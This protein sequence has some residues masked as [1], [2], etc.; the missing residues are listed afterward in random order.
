MEQQGLIKRVHGGAV[1]VSNM[2]QL[3]SL[4]IRNEEYSEEKKTLSMKAINSIE[5]GDIIFIDAGS[6][7]IYFSQ[8][9]KEKFS[10]LTVVT[11]SLDVF[12]ILCHQSDFDVILC[13]DHFKKEENAFYGYLAMSTLEKI[14]V[15]KVFVFPSAISMNFGICD[16][17]EDLYQIQR[18]AIGNADNVLVLADS[19]KFEK[20]LC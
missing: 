10:R 1:E 9:I 2:K 14:H 18:L 11:N 17:Q 6:K 16:F 5:E 7:A 13:G 8:I 12:N 3:S 4:K 19:S 15:Q 20:K